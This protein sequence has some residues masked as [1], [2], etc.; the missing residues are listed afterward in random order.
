MLLLSN[1][2]IAELLHPLLNPNVFADFLTLITA[3]KGEFSLFSGPGKLLQNLVW[4]IADLRGKFWPDLG[5]EIVDLRLQS[6]HLGANC[7]RF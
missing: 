1:V 5:L 7:V 6:V 2:I 4:V 3:E